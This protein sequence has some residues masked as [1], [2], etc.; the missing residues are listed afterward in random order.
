MTDSSPDAA[1][2]A[3]ALKLD[4]IDRKILQALQ[5]DGRKSNIDLAVEVGLSAPPCLRRVK[6]LEEAGII[7]GYSADLDPHKMGF[8]VIV[9]AKV[10]LQTNSD[11]EMD[12]FEKLLENWPMVRE[13]YMLAGDDDYV[14]KIVAQ[15]WEHYQGFVTSQLANAPNV[16]KLSS[17]LVVETV[18]FEHGVP[19]EVDSLTNS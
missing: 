8:K 19:I 9:F 12:A 14:L 6:I 18:K 5:D 17:T 3:R 7:R 4:T 1:A 15:S 2:P 10:S 11:H 13:A 16:A